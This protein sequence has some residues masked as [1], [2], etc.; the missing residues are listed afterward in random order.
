MTDRVMRELN[1]TGKMD[2]R[3]A[4]GYMHFRTRFGLEGLAR[5]I[6]T[7]L[8]LLSVN[9][10]KPGTGQFRNFIVEAKTRFSSVTLWSIMN[11][12][13]MPILARYGFAPCI[14]P[15]VRLNGTRSTTDGMR[16][17]KADAPSFSCPNCKRVSY[18]TKDVEHRY[19]GGCHEFFGAA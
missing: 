4:P 5:V 11:D 9:A 19:C 8:E 2:Y 18:N 14:G 12:E 6:G 1:Q 13:M 3:D 7:D 16:W 15:D 17:R 10:T